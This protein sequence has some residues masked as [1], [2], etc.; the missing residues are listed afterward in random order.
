MVLRLYGRRFQGV[1]SIAGIAL[2]GSRL[3]G[4]TIASFLTGRG[5]G[6]TGRITI[7]VLTPAI[8]SGI[9]VLV[10]VMMTAMFYLSPLEPAG[11]LGVVRL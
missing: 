11:C 5:I 9:Y 4:I 10:C 8:R 3:S 6:K 7:G 1:I 2:T